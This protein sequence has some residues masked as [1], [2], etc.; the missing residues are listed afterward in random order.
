MSHEECKLNFKS[1]PPSSTVTDTKG[2]AKGTVHMLPH[3]IKFPHFKIKSLLVS[4]LKTH[5]L[6]IRGQD[7]TPFFPLYKSI[8]IKENFKNR[9][10]HQPGKGKSRKPWVMRCTTQTQHLAIFWFTFS[11]HPPPPRPQALD[12]S[13]NCNHLVYTNHTCSL[14]HLNYNIS[15]SPM[16]FFLT[17][18]NCTE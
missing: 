3:E 9:Q 16:F 6:S 17:L 11:R 1:A 7:K 14:C 12:V 15:I 2:L 8:L 18:Y 10:N 5:Y 13:C 4:N